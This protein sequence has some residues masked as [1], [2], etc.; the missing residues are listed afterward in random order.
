MSSS[1]FGRGVENKYAAFRVL[2]KY[3]L[4]PV[5]GF[6]ILLCLYRAV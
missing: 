4:I 3:T 5:G 6:F 1:V 2:V